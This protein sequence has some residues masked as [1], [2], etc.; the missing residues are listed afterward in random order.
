MTII[1]KLLRIFYPLRMQFSS[2]TGA[3]KNQTMNSSQIVPPVPFYSLAATGNNGLQAGFDQCRGKYLLIVNL[4]SNCGFTGQYAEL[5]TLYK[6]YKDRLVIL[7][8]PSN[9]F[10]A[11]EPGSDEAIAEFC[12]INYGV[13]FPL[14]TKGM[15]KGE[16]KQP[17]YQWLTD[18]QKNGWNSQEPGWNFCKYLLNTEGRLLAFFSSAVSP[19]SEEIVHLLK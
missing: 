1:Q 16:N 8:F 4:A 7:G 17:V 12:K 9:D 10:G 6:T 5:E 3:G 15:V 2:L 19:L 14:F 11:Q 13:S 18:P